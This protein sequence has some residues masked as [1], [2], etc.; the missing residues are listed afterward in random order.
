MDPGLALPHHG[1]ITEE[2]DGKKP[3]TAPVPAHDSLA[4]RGRAEKQ[5]GTT[6]KRC[7]AQPERGIINLF[8]P[9][10]KIVQQEKTPTIAQQP[11]DKPAH[12]PVTS[13]PDSTRS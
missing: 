10:G 11:T 1:D 9:R 2:S 7:T 5:R 3:L 6:T 4:E 13:Q 8:I 12:E